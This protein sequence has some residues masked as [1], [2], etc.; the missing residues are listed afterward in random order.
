MQE[1]CMPKLL[2][3]ER[4]S[5]SVLHV[6]PPIIIDLLTVQLTVQ[7][8]IKTATKNAKSQQHMNSIKY[9]EKIITKPGRTT[10]IIHKLLF[11]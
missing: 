6:W 1:H 2:L 4:Y 3:K 8:S 5:S 9:W 11:M 7:K 10:K